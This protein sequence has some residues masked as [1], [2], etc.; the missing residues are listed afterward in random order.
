M[1]SITWQDMIKSGE[2]GGLGLV[3]IETLVASSEQKKA[4]AL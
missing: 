2:L 4:I 1:A 3:N